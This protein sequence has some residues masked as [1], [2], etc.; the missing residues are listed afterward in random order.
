MPKLTDFAPQWIDHAGRRGLGLFMTSP[1]N[2]KWRLCVLFANPL[3]GGPAW[4]GESRD[5][6]AVMF[7]VQTEPGKPD[8]KG[9]WDGDVDAEGRWLMACGS[10]R[11]QRTGDTFE[12]L[13]LSP[14]VDAH[15]MGHFTITN[16]QW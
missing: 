11:W 14:S 4:L 3:D 6:L 10:F 16:G 8:A 1:V 5:L 13:S 2:P 7:P 12:S 15:N 9:R